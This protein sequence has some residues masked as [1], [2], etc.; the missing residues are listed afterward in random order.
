[1]RS[2]FRVPLLLVVAL[3]ATCLGV[4]FQVPASAEPT[5][6][7][8]DAAALQADAPH[9]TGT[10]PAGQDYACYIV[11]APPRTTVVFESLA[12]GTSAGL[13]DA[14]GWSLCGVSWDPCRL[15]STGPS[16]LRVHA[17]AGEA[18]EVQFLAIDASTGCQTLAERDFGG[19]GP[20]LTATLRPDEFVCRALNLVAGGH[21]VHG[22]RSH[23]VEWWVYEDATGDMV[24]NGFYTDVCDVP[25]AGAHTLVVG[26][27]STPVD[28]EATVVDLTTQSGCG[29][30]LP[31]TWDTTPHAFALVDKWQVDCLPFDAAP[32]DQ[33]MVG[34]EY[35]FAEVVDATGAV[36][37]H[38][39]GGCVL[40]GPAPYRFVVWQ[41]NPEL[42][43][44]AR[45]AV[46]RA[47][48]E[49]DG[50]PTISPREFGT[51]PADNFPG[52]GCR[53][54]DAV[55]GQKLLIQ[56]FDPKTGRTAGQMMLGPDFKALPRNC[57]LVGFVVCTITTSG[58]YT[59]FGS[60]LGRTAVTAVHDLETWDGCTGTNVDASLR[61]GTL[62]VGQVKCETLAGT[63]E[64]L[65]I[66]EPKVAT[67]PVPVAV[68]D[69]AGE[70]VCNTGYE[71][72]ALTTCDL[73]GPAPFRTLIGSRGSGP[74]A[75]GFVSADD[76]D[77][78]K[79]MPYGA[80]TPTTVTFEAGEFATCFRVVNRARSELLHLTR[81]SGNGLAHIAAVTSSGCGTHE[82]APMVA[83]VC[84]LPEPGTSTK[85]VVVSD[86]RPATFRFVRTANTGKVLNV[87]RP[88]VVGSPR[89]DEVLTADPGLW[90]PAAVLSYRWRA[91][92]V[93]I[94]GAVNPTLTV[95]PALLG[96]RLSV[97][98][99]ATW[100]GRDA[101]SV[102]SFGRT[103]NRGVAPKAVQ[104]P[105]ITGQLQVGSKVTAAV[106]H[107]V[108][109]PSSYAY[110]WYVGGKRIASTSRTI[111]LKPEWAGKRLKLTVITRRPGCWNGSASSWPI[112]VRR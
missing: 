102:Q 67:K 28:V 24:C 99:A 44:P 105:A 10:V 84:S 25:E 101:A 23:P 96:K 43:Q 57:E 78:C 60:L 93:A 37:C 87:R 90:W 112:T 108:R 6:A 98:V 91:N 72:T 8:L 3:V 19:D 1:M 86:G 29:P 50:C 27:Y 77:G 79:S 111:T 65:R 63:G 83:V 100:P 53:R 59:V 39:G 54:I 94:K 69:N 30:R 47:L 85:V 13:Y 58:R 31:T 110:R 32:G 7:V 22:D 92:G 51:T 107:W 82:V 73:N 109:R 52:I 4:T 76:Y 34:A 45:Q 46:V 20:M 21:L 88:R 48:G 35:G 106:G 104:R 81:T 36:A 2:L 97:S 64:K 40:S 61:S 75:Y 11:D 49:G 80:D 89:V 14:N 5:C 95:S 38:I 42:A 12:E 33:V 68:L 74:Y 66:L 16:Q 71:Q 18:Y 62:A 56:S 17:S 55:A 15:S 103:I 41:P 26:D 70:P 9:L